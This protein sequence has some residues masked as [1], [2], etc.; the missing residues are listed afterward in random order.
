MHKMFVIILALHAP[1]YPM[2]STFRSLPHFTSLKSCEEFK[3]ILR[4]TVRRRTKL[5][6][7]ED[8]LYHAAD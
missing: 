3:H 6:C 8:V 1:G 7:A 5:I 2:E 4:S